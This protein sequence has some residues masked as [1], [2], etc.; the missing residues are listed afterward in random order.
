M[1]FLA[2]YLRN[3]ITISVGRQPKRPLLFSYYATHR[4]DLNCRYCCDGD[5]KRFKE[6]PVQELSTD[7]AKR[8]IDVL[9]LSA[10]SLD[11]TGGEPLLREDLGDLLAYARARGMRTILNTKG[12]GLPTRLDVLESTD[13]LVLSVDALN[14]ERLAVLI[15]RPLAV[16]QDIIRDLHACIEYCSKSMRKLV[17]S[18]VATPNNLDD[19]E[20]V[21]SFAESH[22]LGFHVSPEIQG[23]S[24]HPELREHP[25]Y[26]ER[27]GSI[28]QR[29][30]AGA[31]ILGVPEYLAGIQS[32]SRFSC[33]PLLMPVIR[34]DGRLYYPCLESK[35]AE[36][37]LLDHPSYESA[38]EE[39]IRSYGPVPA[40]D[41]RC[42]IFCHMALS[43]LQR[44]PLSALRE[45]QV[46]DRIRPRT[47]QGDLL[48]ARERT[49]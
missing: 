11:I 36:I 39:A 44:H 43:L 38:L 20:A 24:V 30:A 2:N 21:C 6:D 31:A 17:L 22:G 26:H 49:A 37:S 48:H 5:G 45:S 15:G 47:G 8:L 33:W 3:L 12:L 42:H 28:R 1:G 35:E 9:S 7:D 13:V 29:K 41:D 32:F 46:W 27:I 14:P 19:V 34:P 40:C 4:C 25:A 23:T 18:T 10:D 16:A